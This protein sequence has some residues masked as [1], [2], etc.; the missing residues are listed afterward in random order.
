MARIGG[1]MLL[2]AIQLCAKV[3]FTDNL[4]TTSLPTIPQ[5]LFRL[6]DKAGFDMRRVA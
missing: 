2:S 1:A 3:R 4:V 5:N 6:C